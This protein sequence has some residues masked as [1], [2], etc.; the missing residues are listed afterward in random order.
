MITVQVYPNSYKRRISTNIQ[1]E[2]SQ[3]IQQTQQTLHL[4]IRCTLKPLQTNFS[5][6]VVYPV[7]L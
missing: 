1:G 3:L 2:S 7:S 6:A 5:I 4:Q